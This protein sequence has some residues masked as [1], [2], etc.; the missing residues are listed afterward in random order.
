LP[1]WAI[2]QATVFIS[3][4]LPDVLRA[5]APEKVEFLE[6]KDAA[7]I[8]YGATDII[9]GEAGVRPGESGIRR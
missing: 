5:A 7:V 4:V 1:V 9:P 3:C 8:S 6:K 2:P